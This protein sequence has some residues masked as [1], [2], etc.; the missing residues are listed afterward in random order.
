MDVPSDSPFS[1]MRNGICSETSRLGKVAD[2]LRRRLP[3]DRSLD[4]LGQELSVGPHGSRVDAALAPTDPQKR[5]G[6]PHTGFHSLSSAGSSLMMPGT[7]SKSTSAV[8]MRITSRRCIT[9][10]CRRSRVL[11]P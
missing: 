10:R 7:R 8:T 11:R 5:I 9:A 4:R 2:A 6:N 3:P 1:M